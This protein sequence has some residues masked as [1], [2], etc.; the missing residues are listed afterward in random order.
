MMAM[1][2][3][4]F[5]AGRS[6]DTAGS[7]AGAGMGTG[8]AGAGIRSKPGGVGVV[9]ALLKAMGCPVSLLGMGGN[10]REGAICAPPSVYRTPE[11]HRPQGTR[12]AAACAG[13]EEVRCRR[14]K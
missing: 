7:A 8:T 9:W 1:L 6:R 12:I 10:A 4:G 2:K 14:R 11:R 13:D 3:I 5:G